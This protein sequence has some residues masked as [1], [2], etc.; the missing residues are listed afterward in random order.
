MNNNSSAGLKS[1]ATTVDSRDFYPD[2]F[3][4]SWHPASIPQN[5]DLRTAIVK[6]FRLKQTDDYVYHAIAS[7]TLS[8]VQV[9]IDHGDVNGMH[10]WYRD[11]AGQQVTQ[12]PFMS[13]LY[14]MIVDRLVDT[15]TESDRYRSLCAD[16]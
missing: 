6:S 2:Q 4:N 10:A 7:V 9:A 13:S 5:N 1:K 12:S 14:L 3:L 16:L 11:V 15:T 8:Q